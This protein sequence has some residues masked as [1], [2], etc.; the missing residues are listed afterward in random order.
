MKK[1]DKDQ[2]IS[3]LKFVMF[4]YFFIGEVS[5]GLVKGLEEKV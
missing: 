3:L 4:L 2:T 1:E 5:H